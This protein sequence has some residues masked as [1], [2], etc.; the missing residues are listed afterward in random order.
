M[1]LRKKFAMNCSFY[2]IPYKLVEDYGIM[3]KLERKMSSC[4][5]V[6]LR[7]TSCQDPKQNENKQF[8]ISKDIKSFMTWTKC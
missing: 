6:E 5:K 2:R 3:E 7:C 8:Q 4:N 1:T